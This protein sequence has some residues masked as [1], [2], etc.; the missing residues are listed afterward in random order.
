LEKN[1]DE[2]FTQL[3]TILNDPI[4]AIFIIILMEGCKHRFF[5]NYFKTKEIRTNY[6]PIKLKWHQNLRIKFTILISLNSVFHG[7]TKLNPISLISNKPQLKRTLKS[8]GVTEGY[9]FENESDS[10]LEIHYAESTNLMPLKKN[11]TEFENS[12]GKKTYPLKI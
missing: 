1:L 3:D 12:V 11:Q 9:E 6:E 2:V 8:K 10:Q 7:A 5:S 4:D